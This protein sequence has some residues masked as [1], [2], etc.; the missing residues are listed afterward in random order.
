MGG[1]M[2][3]RIGIVV[4]IATLTSSSAYAENQWRIGANLASYHIAST[5]EFNQLNLGVFV[6]TTF[7]SEHAF[8]YGVQIGGYSNSYRER[9]LYTLAFANWKVLDWKGAELRMGGF[10]GFFEYPNLIDQVEEANWPHIGNMVLALGPSMVI[11][12]DNG[13]DL[14]FGYLPVHGKEAKGVITLQTSFAFGGN[15]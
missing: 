12:M 8:Q 5:E 3:N 11:R 10:T 13:I 7:R 6:S 2:V 1:L 14:T 4:T 9:T 15:R